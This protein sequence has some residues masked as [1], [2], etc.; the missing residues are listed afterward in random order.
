METSQRD[1]LHT[2]P[3][4]KRNS[5][6]SGSS[7]RLALSKP[8]S[9]TT[10]STKTSSRLMSSVRRS[11][12]ASSPGHKKQ[13]AT[14]QTAGMYSTTAERAVQHPPRFK[15]PDPS[16][17][18]PSIEQIA[19]GL[20][21]SRTPHLRSSSAPNYPFTQ[22]THPPT[23]LPPP[24]SRSAL[25]KPSSSA[26]SIDPP[27]NSSTTV[28]SSNFPYTPRSNRSLFSFKSRVSRLLPGS[29]YSSPSPQT[30]TSDFVPPKKAVRFSTSTLNLDEEK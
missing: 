24:P 25:K 16:S 9:N 3:T 17:S 22:R 2:R 13:L 18:P 21:I 27:S 28:T 20:H 15:R 23:P 4:H 1:P 8:H 12:F 6:S 11:L 10:T 14:T 7:S 5:H 30:S 26:P 19:M 29:Q